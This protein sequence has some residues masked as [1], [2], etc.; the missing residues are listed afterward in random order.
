M[1]D[2]MKRQSSHGLPASNKFRRPDGAAERASYSPRSFVVCGNP[3]RV[4]ARLAEQ[5]EEM[6]AMQ[7]FLH[8][9]PL[10]LHK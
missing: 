10:M 2:L 9:R 5:F 1:N 3:D 6:A 4:V 8:S 7:I